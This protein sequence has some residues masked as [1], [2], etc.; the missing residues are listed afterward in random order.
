MQ[1]NLKRLALL[2]G[3]CARAFAARA[4]LT[5]QRIDL[6]LLVRRYAMS[7]VEIADRLCVTP[8]VI[9]RM[10]AA[11]RE[12]GLVITVPDRRD[13]RMRVPRLTEQG[14]AR[15]ALCFPTRTTRGAQTT[16]EAQWLAVW[17][18]HLAA[19]GIR[20]DS[21]LRGYGALDFAVYRHWRRSWRPPRAASTSFGAHRPWSS[22]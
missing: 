4:G 12:L 1:L 15:L 7:Q 10:V 19:N 14:Q 6:M 3:P 5:P 9:S 21:V 20:V 17:R 22:S 8:P 16:G 13:A 18:P 2:A 11:L